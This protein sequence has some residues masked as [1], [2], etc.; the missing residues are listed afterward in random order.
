MEMKLHDAGRGPH[1]FVVCFEAGQV[2]VV[3]P[4]LFTVVGVV[5]F[6]RGPTSIAFSPRD[7]TTAYVSEFIDNDIAVV[8][9][10]PGSP[11]EYRVVQR[12]GF[13]RASGK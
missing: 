7:P 4:R 12:L 6:G 13:P 10:R 11:T 2:Y 5:N 9:F 3:D 1:V 8:D